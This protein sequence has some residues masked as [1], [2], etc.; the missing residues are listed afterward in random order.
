MPAGLVTNPSY[1]TPH[2]K[3]PYN[4]PRQ[5]DKRV[6]PYVQTAFARDE[7][8]MPFDAIYGLANPRSS[9]Q[10]GVPTHQ[11]NRPAAHHMSFHGQ[12]QMQS[13]P[14]GKPS[15]PQ[16][17]YQPVSTH[18]PNGPMVMM[19]PVFPNPH[20]APTNSNF[21]KKPLVVET[22]RSR[23]LGYRLTPSHTE[24]AN[25]APQAVSEKLTTC[26]VEH[27]KTTSRPGVFEAVP[28]DNAMDVDQKATHPSTNDNTNMKRLRPLEIPP[29]RLW[30]SATTPAIKVSGVR[31]SL[32][33]S[34]SKD[35]AATLVGSPS[36]SMVVKGATETR[37]EGE[38]VVG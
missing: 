23:L 27:K 19:H 33:S 35:S 2:Y 24:T 16:V 15:Q 5:H 28:D 32:E 34:L 12:P 17:F 26:P 22:G 30:S 38:S 31:T 29:A 3:P 21:D 1:P 25:T 37:G 9:R 36:E 11:P 8:A 10:R 14:P 13:R 6:R 4:D 20:M 18:G 7:I